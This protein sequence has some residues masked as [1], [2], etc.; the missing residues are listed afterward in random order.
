MR[1]WHY[2]RACDLFLP[3]GVLDYHAV[4]VKCGKLVDAYQCYSIE[5]W[6]NVA[7]GFNC[8]DPLSKIFEVQES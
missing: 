8:L 6:E 4:C 3:P 5:K 7:Y 2:I 1:V